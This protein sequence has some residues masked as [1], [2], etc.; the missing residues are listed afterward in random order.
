MKIGKREQIV[1]ISIGAALV[2]F[3]THFFVFQPRA[4]KYAEVE[5]KY[6]EGVTKLT[7]GEVAPSPTYVKTF[8][9]K[10]DEYRA[11]VT[12]AVAVL[13]LDIAQ[14]YLSSKEEAYE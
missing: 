11:E 3:L 10:T 6:K 14:Q 9:A 13:N 2:I 4:L 12:S 5:T 1:G 8:E 7:S